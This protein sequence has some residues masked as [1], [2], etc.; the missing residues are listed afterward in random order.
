MRL[1]L[2]KFTNTHYILHILI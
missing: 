2:L 1:N